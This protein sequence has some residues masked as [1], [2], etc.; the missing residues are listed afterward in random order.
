MIKIRRRRELVFE[1]KQEKEV[2]ERIQILLNHDVIHNKVT[3]FTNDDYPD[4]LIAKFKATD[5]EFITI[6]GW[7]AEFLP[8]ARS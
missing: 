8:K 1:M 3:F 7:L 2:C 5:N 4:K 6:V